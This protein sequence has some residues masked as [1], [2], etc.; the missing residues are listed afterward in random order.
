[1]KLIIGLGNPGKQYQN[2]RH[3][4]G[5]LIIDALRQDLKFENWQS[6]KK[7]H[8]SVSQGV[9]ANEK[10]ILAKP[11]TFMNDS[12]KTAKLLADYYQIGSEQILAV[13]DEADL[14]FGE[15]RCQPG[16]GAAGHRGVE[17]LINHLKTNIF[18]RIRIGIFCR[19]R[20]GINP[21]SGADK[22]LEDF[23]LEKF[24]PQEEESIPGIINKSLET[25]KKRLSPSP[26]L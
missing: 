16:R 6:S 10:I 11:E 7:F 24:T 14:P 18:C 4:L 13:H 21:E 22:S 25:I 8:A 15:I 3:N 19:I 12:G 20:I 26:F 2:T 5:F 17:S 1:M 9:F 23:V